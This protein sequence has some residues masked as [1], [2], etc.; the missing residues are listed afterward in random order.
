MILD[1]IGRA[2]PFM[3]E[4]KMK[5]FK[6][7]LLV[8][9]SVFLVQCSKKPI[10]NNQPI[11]EEP[12][13]DLPLLE[14]ELIE[15]DNRFGLKLF[16][17]IVKE[18]SSDSNIF[19]SPLSVAMALGMTYNGA[20]GETQEAMQKTL[21][22]E[23][24]TLEEVNQ[25][26]QH[27]TESLTQLDPK[28]EFGLANSIW[29]HLAL[30]PREEFLDLCQE[31]FNAL[32]RGLNFSNPDAADTINGWVEEKTNGKIKDLVNKPIGPSI[33]MFLINA[34][35]FK[36]DWTY[37]FDKADTK[38]DWFYLTN[39]SKKLCKMMEQRGLFNYF[40]NDV[41]QVVDL[42]YGDED[43]SMTIFVPKYGTDINS[44]IEEFDQDKLSYWFTCLERDSVNVYLPK[45]KLEYGVGLNHALI[46]LGMGI[47]F[48]AGADFSRMYEGG[49]V[50]IDSVKHKSF[51]EVNEEGTEA[52]AA[53]V[54][55]MK[56]GGPSVLQ[57]RVD[58][59]F[60][61][62]IRENASGTILFI[63]KIVHPGFEES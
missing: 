30:T 16:E 49:G 44:L 25:C 31:Y 37:Q 43:F 23:G 4:A 14:K 7:F 61:F 8:L 33:L 46:T 13:V 3:K 10:G 55:I 54:V 40:E 51:I 58:R 39:G 56:G 2:N 9:V 29:Y 17:E 5:H 28:V 22:L 35:Y 38:D 45:F 53:T 41:I 48:F 24:F 62:M 20:N 57:I 26:Y 59:P 15:A 52:A 12:I 1:R 19:I 63:G 36:G 21:E 34:I 42:P 32:V 27:L 60:V 11:P 18:E 50:Y 47:G 6:I